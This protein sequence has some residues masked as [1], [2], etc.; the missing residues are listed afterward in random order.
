MGADFS[1]QDYRGH[2]DKFR[3]DRLTLDHSQMLDDFFAASEDFANVFMSVSLADYRRL[4]AEKPENF[5]HLLS[6][7]SAII[8]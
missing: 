3:K 4:K 2:L 5:I 1:Q 6:Y 8:V 7:V